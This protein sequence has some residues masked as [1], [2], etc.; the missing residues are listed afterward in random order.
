MPSIIV[1][2]RVRQSAGGRRAVGLRSALGRPEAEA[3]KWGGDGGCGIPHGRDIMPGCVHMR[4]C[5]LVS[6]CVNFVRVCVCG[7]ARSKGGENRLGAVQS[8]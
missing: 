5:I 1:T 4:T 8:S 6:V 3:A 7:R 2:C